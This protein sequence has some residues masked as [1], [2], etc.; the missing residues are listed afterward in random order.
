MFIE[1]A[2]KLLARIKEGLDQDSFTYIIRSSAAWNVQNINYQPTPEEQQE[3]AQYLSQTVG[4][5]IPLHISNA[6]LDLY[7]SVKIGL[8]VEGLET[9]CRDGLAFAVAHF[10]TGC[11]WPRNKENQGAFYTLL[12]K[13][14]SLVLEELGEPVVEAADPVFKVETREDEPSL[15]PSECKGFVIF[16]S[17]GKGKN[18]QLLNSWNV[19]RAGDDSGIAK[20]YEG[21]VPVLMDETPSLCGF[22]NFAQFSATIRKSISDFCSSTDALVAAGKLP[23]LKERWESASQAEKQSIAAAMLA[24]AAKQ[25]E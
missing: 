6:I 1:D 18:S 20:E 9:S 3:V 8:S 11:D 13:Q 24:G 10:F 7:P 19:F 22:P 21:R 12:K 23:D 25:S 15:L 2:D 16:G 4:I 14:A 5:E 17:D